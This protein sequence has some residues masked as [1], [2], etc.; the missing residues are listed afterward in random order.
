[1]LFHECLKDCE[2]EKPGVLTVPHTLRSDK[3]YTTSIVRVAK[4][5][6]SFRYVLCVLCAVYCGVY[7]LLHDACVTV[8][9]SSRYHPVCDLLIFLF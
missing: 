2:E 1:M 5:L 6:P 3:D 8:Q 9:S 7:E 4:Y